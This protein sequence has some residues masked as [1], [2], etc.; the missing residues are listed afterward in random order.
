VVS[1][2]QV[3][4]PPYCYRWTV[5]IAVVITVVG[6]TVWAVQPG[7]G[8]APAGT[9]HSPAG[10]ALSPAVGASTPSAAIPGLVTHAAGDG[11]VVALTFDDGPHPHYTPQVLALLAEHHAVATFCMVG[12]QAA[13]YPEL[14]RRVAAAGM[15]LCAHSMTHDEQLPTRPAPS[16]EAEIV[17]G[18]AV[19]VAAAGPDTAVD[20]FRAPAGN[21]SERVQLVASR[22]NMKSLSWSVDSRDWTQPG[23]AQI[24]ATVQRE[25]QPG[26]VVLLHDG[27]GQRDQTVAALTELLPWLI[28]QGYTFGI[29]D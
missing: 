25:V 12:Y 5:L 18:R 23:A 22:N 19:L 1:R 29:P 9:A 13:R 10:Q 26:A 20:H 8:G 27:G 3:W 24:L 4:R 16:M 21:W 2:C 17:G 28:A 7:A 15:R 14:V 6:L 11:K